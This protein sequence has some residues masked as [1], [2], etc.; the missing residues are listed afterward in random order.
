MKVVGK[1]MH[2]NDRWFLTRILSDVNAVLLS[3]YKLLYEVHL[4]SKS[5]PP[6][7]ALRGERFHKPSTQITTF[8]ASSN[9]RKIQALDQSEAA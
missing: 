9:H 8:H 1:A 2:Q 7:A 5:M 4:L 3:L 6:N